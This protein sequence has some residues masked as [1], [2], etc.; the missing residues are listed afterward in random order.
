M[1]SDFSLSSSPT[2]RIYD[3]TN[4]KILSSRNV[5]FIECVESNTPPM[6]DDIDKRSKSSDDLENVNDRI[7]NLEST[8]R[9]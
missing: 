4:D 6:V 3:N 7:Q 8:C 5:T 2:Y 1:R 9:R